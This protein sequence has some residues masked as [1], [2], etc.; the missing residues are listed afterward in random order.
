LLRRQFVGNVDETMTECRTLSISVGRPWEEVYDYLAEPGNFP[1]WS[2]FITGMRPDGDEWV[3]TTP[4]G[5]V[6]MRFGPR[7]E[8]GVL[9]HWVSP[10]A[11]VTIYVPLRVLANGAA[12]EVTF[13]VFRQPNMSDADFAEDIAMVQ[14]DLASLKTKLESR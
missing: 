8:F 2:K 14:R 3:A 10:N 6:K 13:S 1:H 11:S 9:D 5:E 4:N 12:S 7:N